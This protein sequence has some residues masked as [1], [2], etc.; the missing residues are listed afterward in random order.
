[1]GSLHEGHMA[2]VHQS[3]EENDRTA[4]SIF[5]NPKQ[6]EDPEAARQYPEQYEQDEA[7]LVQ[8]GVDWLYR[9]EVDDVYPDGDATHVVVRNRL[10]E[11][12]EAQH[13]EQFFDGVTRV[14][15]KLMNTIPADRLYMG[16]KDLQ[17]LLVVR[18]LVRDLRMGTTVRPV[19]VV[20]DDQG[21]A[22]S[23]RNQALSQKSRGRL[24]HFSQHLLKYRDNPPDSQETFQE[25]VTEAARRLK[26]DLDYASIVSVPEL[27]ST[28]PDTPSA[29]IVVA[30]HLDGVRVKDNV[31]L[32]SDS[33]E[34]L[35][36]GR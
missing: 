30:G 15:A 7:K 36:R 1:M 2:L 24:A 5:V 22:R 35:L 21:I 17:Q 31:P 34:A 3:L 6:F 14:L 20:R 28:P 9:P 13:R 19:P 4:V 26:I 10:T 33:V 18:R 8:T 32:H 23:S 16:E 11:V 27:E 25:Q 29:T 12:L